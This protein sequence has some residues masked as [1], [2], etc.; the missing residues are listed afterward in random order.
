MQTLFVYFSKF[1]T[2]IVQKQVISNILQSQFLRFKK[3]FY[4]GDQRAIF[5]GFPQKDTSTM[6][7]N[8]DIIE[9]IL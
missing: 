7:K 8:P 1:L 5:V 9:T 6:G 3:K 4:N 2:F